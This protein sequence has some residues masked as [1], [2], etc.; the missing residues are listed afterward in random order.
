MEEGKLDFILEPNGVPQHRKNYD[1][2]RPHIGFSFWMTLDPNSKILNSKS[3]RK[4]FQQELYWNFRKIA[5]PNPPYSFANQLFLPGGAGRLDERKAIQFWKG[6]LS[7]KSSRTQSLRILTSPSFH[8]FGALERALEATARQLNLKVEL[9][10][11]EDQTEFS[12]LLREANP[13]AYL[14]NN[15]FS[16]FD[17]SL[18]LPVTFN[19]QKP[20]IVLNDRNI[21][22]EILSEPI[23]ERRGEKLVALSKKLLDE[24]LIV[25]LAHRTMYFAKSNRFDISSWSNLYPEI[26]FWKAKLLP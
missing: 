16:G 3:L 24:A 15:D 22:Q 1:V 14:T 10:R 11:Y 9:I 25:P 20:L 21:L 5:K 26:S 4:Q 7:I 12:R 18:A 19:E 13:D 8:L 17:L 6:A 2:L 23:L